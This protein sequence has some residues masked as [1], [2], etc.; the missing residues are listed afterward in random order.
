M[1]FSIQVRERGVV[2]LP[3]ELSNPDY[4]KLN[5][6]KQTGPEAFF[7]YFWALELMNLVGK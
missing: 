6:V 1:E 3:V 7:Y 2:T 5:K 4:N